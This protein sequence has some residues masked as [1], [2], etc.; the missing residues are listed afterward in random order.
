MNKVI[1]GTIMALSILFNVY[2]AYEL[3]NTHALLLPAQQQGDTYR[4]LLDAEEAEKREV[5]LI[6]FELR[7]RNMHV[8]QVVLEQWAQSIQLASM[9]H[10]IKV[11][12]LMS[13]YRVESAFVHYDR[14]GAITVSH[15]G[16]GGIGQIMPFWY[17]QCPYSRTR[18]DLT[19]THVNIMCSAYILR[20]YMDLVHDKYNVSVPSQNLY[21]ALVAYN[22]GPS[23]IRALLRGKDITESYGTKVISRVI[24]A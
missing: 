3:D 12:V 8:P 7:N 16:A 15:K 19:N 24:Q 23:G 10:N 14:T 9:R 11:S 1:F 4:D 18:Q 22:A 21:L 20:G 2:Q 13:L 17:K 5:M 6:A